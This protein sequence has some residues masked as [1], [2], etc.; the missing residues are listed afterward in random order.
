MC[1]CEKCDCSSERGMI[2][3]E[4]DDSK[5]LTQPEKDRLKE[6]LTEDTINLLNKLTGSCDV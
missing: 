2:L 6:I 5:H 4:I 1:E 3:K